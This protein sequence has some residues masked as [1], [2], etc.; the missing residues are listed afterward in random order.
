MSAARAHC[1][2]HGTFFVAT[3]ACQVDDARWLV[4]V[5]CPSGHSITVQVGP[6]ERLWLRANAATD[7]WQPGCFRVLADDLDRFARG[8]VAL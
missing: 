6:W 8:E 7:M 2:V 5:P 3:H 4:V 1:A